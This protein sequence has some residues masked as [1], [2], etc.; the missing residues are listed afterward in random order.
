VQFIS[1]I[2]DE[3]QIALSGLHVVS[4]SSYLFLFALALLLACGFEFINGFHDAANA[5]ATVIYTRSLKPWA[6]VTW[7]GFCN[8]LGAFLGGTTVAMGILKLLP[9]DL[10]ITNQLG[11]SFAMIF[12]FLSAAILWNLSI[13]ILA[14]PASSSHALI[15]SMLGIG[16]AN[17]YAT[18]APLS[19]GINWVKAGEIGIALLLSPLLGFTLS[20]IL[21]IAS[22]RFFPNPIVHNA[23]TAESVPP[24]KV[25]ATLILT[26][27]GISLAHGSN[28]GQKGVALIM[29][30]LMTVL[31]EQF[32]LRA[33]LTPSDLQATALASHRM[34]DLL[35][36]TKPT[37]LSQKSPTGIVLA[38]ATALERGSESKESLMVGE[39]LN[40]VQLI[41]DKLDHKPSL[42]L[43]T[44]DDR[45]EL[46]SEILKV[47]QKISKLEHN[48]DSGISPSTWAELKKERKQLNKLTD[49]APTWVMLI[50]ALSLGLGT[51]IGWK[52]IVRTVG[53]RIGKSHMTYAQ[54]ASAELVA[55]GTIG[56][57]A[58]AG[59]PVSTTHVLSSGIAGTM[60]AGRTG[61]QSKTVKNIILAW[62]LTL[63]TVMMLSAGLYLLF[64]R[65]F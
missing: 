48:R 63:P 10:L 37:P 14:L 31:P 15:G 30:I 12:A 64:I 42:Q 27:S 53:E 19:E 21:L 55:M 5:V 26:S 1:A 39:I 6:A 24:W 51:L 29:L 8:F 65:I 32:A 9:G 44:V 61:I 52:R 60:I 25:R 3:I 33:T 13:W 23:P 7:S 59:L 16:L 57:S 54:G 35:T 28:D 43:L 47:D 38:A 41:A 18:G 56:L 34:K 4:H 45:I 46:R 50:V 62:T 40:S 17:A 58:F 2:T 36:N 22:Q 11:I 20:G 49:Y